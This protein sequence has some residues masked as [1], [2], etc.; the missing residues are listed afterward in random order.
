MLFFHF[1]SFFFFF[2]LYFSALSS[3]GS[4]YVLSSFHF[5]LFL[6][7]DKIFLYIM[8]PATKMF[9][10]WLWGQLSLVTGDIPRGGS[11]YWGKKRCALLEPPGKGFFSEVPKSGLGRRPGRVIKKMGYN[12]WQR[13]WTLP[14]IMLSE[15]TERGNTVWTHLYWESF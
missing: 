6:A 4:G 11:K 13:G 2:L 14:S 5:G 9:S 12:L 1:F 10:C 15:V 7:L 8:V 3:E